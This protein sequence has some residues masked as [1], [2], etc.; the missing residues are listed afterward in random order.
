MHGQHHEWIMRTGV[1]H[2]RAPAQ[3]S[4]PGRQGNPPCCSLTMSN[5][6]FSQVGPRL[7]HG[8]PPCLSQ[9]LIFLSRLIV[10]TLNRCL[11]CC[12]PLGTSPVNS[13]GWKM[14]VGCLA[15]SQKLF[16]SLGRPINFQKSLL[17]GPNPGGP[18]ILT[19]SMSC[20]RTRAT[21]DWL[22]SIFHTCCRSMMGSQRSDCIIS[23]TML[24]DWGA[25]C[26]DHYRFQRKASS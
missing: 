5:G 19:G 15:G 25:A 2:R 23:A 18:I 24:C 22:Q 8:R 20:G 10:V 11:M 7:N 12:R 13:A 26:S 14:S 6:T 1:H 17:T 21:A 4:G 16:T 3:V 9:K